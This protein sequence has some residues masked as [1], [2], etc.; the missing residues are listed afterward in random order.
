[1]TLNE[2]TKALVLLDSPPSSLLLGTVC[3]M[4]LRIWFYPHGILHPSGE[5]T[6]S[7]LAY[8]PCLYFFPYVT[9]FARHLLWFLDIFLYKWWF[10]SCLWK[11]YWLFKRYERNHKKITMN[12]MKCAS[13]FLPHMKW[14]VILFAGNSCYV[15]MQ[16]REHQKMEIILNFF[17]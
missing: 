17:M 8:L 13:S 11:K 12:C 16:S 6:F 4:Q 1:M 14:N 3:V 2:I 10:Y 5:S 15:W 9:W 7:L